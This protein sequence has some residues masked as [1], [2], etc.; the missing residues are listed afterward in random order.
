MQ[1]RDCKHTPVRIGNDRAFTGSVAV[2][3]YTEENPCAHGNI[4]FT[5]ECTRCGA[6][7]SV[8]VNGRHREYGPY[9]P[10]RAR[11]DDLERREAARK[12]NEQESMARKAALAAGFE[13]IDA[14]LG[15]LQADGSG[16]ADNRSVSLRVRGKCISVSL[17]DIRAAASQEDNGDGLVQIYSGVLLIIGDACRRKMDELRKRASVCH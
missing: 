6:Q 11:R 4:T 13:L 12:R 15:R 5:E 8:N 16:L 1:S 10:T 7:R 9:G 17:A 14:N 3:P 2:Q